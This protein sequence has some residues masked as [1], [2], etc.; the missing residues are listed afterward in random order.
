VAERSEIIVRISRGPGGRDGGDTLGNATVDKRVSRGSLATLYFDRVVAQASAAGADPG[1]LL[2][3]A[4]AHEIGHLLMGTTA[5]APHGLMRARWSRTE[6]QRQFQRDW[7]FSAN[8]AE[9][10]RRQVAV[11]DRVVLGSGF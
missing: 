7:L 11:R 6:L 10:M 9:R 1:I 5:H 4:A 2:G 8:D 3:R